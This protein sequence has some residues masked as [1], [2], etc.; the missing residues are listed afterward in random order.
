MSGA[1]HVRLGCVVVPV[2]VVVEEVDSRNR[3]FILS[4]LNGGKFT[5]FE[6]FEEKLKRHKNVIFQS[7][8]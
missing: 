3:R 5:S 4:L 6:V 1:T 7:E 8:F 2:V